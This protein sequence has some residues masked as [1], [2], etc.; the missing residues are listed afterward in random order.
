MHTLQDDPLVKHSLDLLA[1]LASYRPTPCSPAT[2]ADLCSVV[3]D[4]AAKSVQFGMRASALRTLQALLVVRREQHERHA[5]TQGLLGL[6]DS[7]MTAA[8]DASDV[9]DNE[10]SAIIAIQV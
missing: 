7:V 10:M 4:V 6:V 1:L 8:R 5:T 9:P 3:A 2:L